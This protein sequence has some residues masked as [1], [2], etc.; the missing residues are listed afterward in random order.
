MARMYPNSLDSDTQ[1]QA[2]RDLYALFRDNL[3]DEYVV[4]HSVRWQVRRPQGGVLDGEADFVIAHPSSGI[5]VLEVKGGVITFD[6]WTGHWYTNGNRLG[7]SPLKQA[8]DNM[9]RLRDKLESRLAPPTMG[10]AVAFPDVEVG[11]NLRIDSLP[12]TVFDWRDRR[13]VRGWVERALACYHRPD[14]FRPPLGQRGIDTVI[15][16]LSPTREIRHPM[17]ASIEKEGEQI[18]ELT[19]EQARLLDR[20]RGNRRMA[21][22][23]CAGSGKTM[24]ALHKARRLSEDGLRVLLTCFNTHL[25]EYL[26]S[27]ESLPKAV[28]VLT[29]HGVRRK[30]IKQ[31]GLESATPPNT[32]LTDPAV[33]EAWNSLMGQ[34]IDRV[35][36]PYDAII[37]DE[38]RDFREAWW[39]PLQYLLRDLDHGILYIFYDDNQ[40]LYQQ[41]IS[42][43][44]GLLPASLSENCRNTQHVHRTFV[45]FYRG[46]TLPTTQGPL[47]RPVEVRTYDSERT[48]KQHIQSVLHTLHVVERV[49]TEDIVVLTPRSS[50]TS[51]LW[52]LQPFGNFRL[53]SR[54]DDSSGVYCNSVY[55]FKGLESPVVILAEVYPSQKQDLEALLYVGASRACHHLVIIAHRDLP[56]EILSRLPA[57]TA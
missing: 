42:L 49:P 10:H 31:A 50:E 27:A 22:A 4:F 30:L 21:I 37:V 19:K 38:G 24:L 11:D 14:E 32:W 5:L 13:D 16:I 39:L 48:M 6:G 8:S 36:A 46:G 53:S 34:A 55:R 33:D 43:P 3:P 56:P 18:L 2:E 25:A 23:G 41:P 28:D 44:D 47:G 54:W 52:R 1:S 12:E 40:N 17:A 57:A 35:G 7:R 45:P 9:Y 26:G 29:Y 20:L 51:E 15:D